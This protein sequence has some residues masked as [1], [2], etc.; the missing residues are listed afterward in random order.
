MTS[1]VLEGGT[2]RPIFSCGVMDALLDAEIM[3]PYI[4]GVSAGS[5]MVS[6]MPPVRKDAIW[7][8]SCATAMIRVIFLCATWSPTIRLLA[9]ALSSRRFPMN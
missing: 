5:R 9:F 8:S 2:F 4:I 7:R 6:P 3:L 1:L